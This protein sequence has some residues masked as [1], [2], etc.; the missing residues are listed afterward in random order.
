MNKEF[1][2][3]LVSGGSKNKVLSKFVRQRISEKHK[4]KK[5]SK[6]AIEKLSKAVVQIDSETFVEE[7]ALLR[8]DFIGDL[9]MNMMIHMFLETSSGEAMSILTKKD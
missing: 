5:M 4:G 9:K 1:G 7:K 6:E 3:N 8:V 2:Y